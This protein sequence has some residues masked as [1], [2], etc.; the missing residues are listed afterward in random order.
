M[1]NCSM[2][3]IEGYCFRYI[4][5]K[6]RQPWRSVL[7]EVDVRC[8]GQVQFWRVLSDPKLRICSSAAA[9]VIPILGPS[10]RYPRT[11]FLTPVVLVII[12]QNLHWVGEN[13]DGGV[14]NLSV[15]D[16]AATSYCEAQHI[17]QT[18]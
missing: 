11:I 8:F 14:S 1:I 15:V 12:Y 10:N 17:L 5:V 3:T 2:V 18:C 16:L 6:L 7:S 13:G 4:I 9:S